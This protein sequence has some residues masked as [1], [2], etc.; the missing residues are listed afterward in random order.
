MGSTRITRG[1][2]AARNRVAGFPAARRAPRFKVRSVQYRPCAREFAHAGSGC[3]QRSDKVEP[4]R[5]RWSREST[6]IKLRRR[7]Q[8]VGRF[9][10]DPD[11]P[12]MLAKWT[13]SRTICHHEREFSSVSVSGVAENPHFGHFV[14]FMNQSRPA[15]CD[16]AL[17]AC[18]N[19]L[20]PQFRHR[21]STHK[22][23]RTGDPRQDRL[24]E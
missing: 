14:L 18:Q 11:Y 10:R 3:A 7:L 24:K 20:Y 23:R 6:Y 12:R 15:G 22:A 13:E 8:A 17:I 1:K 21:Q 2:L 4:A 19:N 5:G 16:R 9:T